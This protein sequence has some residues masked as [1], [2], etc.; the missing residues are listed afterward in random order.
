LACIGGHLK[1]YGFFIFNTPN[2]VADEMKTSREFEYW[3]DFLDA[4]GNRVKVYEMQRYDSL[5]NTVLY[6]T[7]RIW[8]THHTF[9]KI[10]LKFINYPSLLNL[11]NQAWFEIL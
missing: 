8:Q 9:S 5:N 3:H 6:T 7:K 1:S 2:T 10:S 4:N 11:V